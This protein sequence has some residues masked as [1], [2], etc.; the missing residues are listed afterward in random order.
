VVRLDLY[1]PGNELLS[2][3][4]KFTFSATRTG[5]APVDPNCFP[6]SG[7]LPNDQCSYTGN[8]EVTQAVP[9]PTTFALLTIALGGMAGVRHGFKS[10]PRHR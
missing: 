9:V 3:D 6:N 7:G 1:G 8:Y 5:Q 2:S 10:R 4:F